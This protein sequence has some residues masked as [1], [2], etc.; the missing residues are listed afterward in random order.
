[1]RKVPIILLAIVVAVSMCFV[2]TSCGSISCSLDGIVLSL[3]S[4][5]T[6]VIDDEAKSS[7]SEQ[8]LEEKNAIVSSLN[9][10][11]KD[12]PELADMLSAG[13]RW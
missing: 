12:R 11:I 6:F 2:F 9:R 4:H 8:Q 5:P 10:A 3:D 1:M 7:M 13:M